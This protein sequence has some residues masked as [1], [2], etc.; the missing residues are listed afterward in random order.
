MTCH[1][2]PSNVTTHWEFMMGMCFLEA[3]FSY[4]SY[5]VLP[6]RCQCLSFKH[7]MTCH[8]VVNLIQ[9]G[10]ENMKRESLDYGIL[11]CALTKA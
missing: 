8:D 5:R 7:L 10:N 4:K 2:L 3:T 9:R 6:S 1:D 11:F